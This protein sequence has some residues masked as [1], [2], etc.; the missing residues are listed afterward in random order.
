MY[1][2]QITHGNEY[3]LCIL[4]ICKLHMGIIIKMWV[5]IIHGKIW[6]LWSINPL[7]SK[8]WYRS[9]MTCLFPS[10]SWAYTK[11]NQRFKIFEQFKITPMV[12]IAH[13]ETCS[14]GILHFWNSLP[15]DYLLLIFL[16]S[17]GWKMSSLTTASAANI[18]NTTSEPIVCQWEFLYPLLIT[19]YFL[20]IFTFW[21]TTIFPTLFLLN[22]QWFQYSCGHSS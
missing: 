12:R 6:Y 19:L 4:P 13:L 17:R 3:Y 14:K 18:S 21:L 22:S 2:L 10:Q 11:K 7:F 9:N 15:F 20:M 1:N 16:R 5:C 8:L